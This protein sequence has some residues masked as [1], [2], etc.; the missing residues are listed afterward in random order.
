MSLNEK[1]Y[2]EV[3]IEA[4]WVFDPSN[5]S[6]NPNL[7]VKNGLSDVKEEINSELV[8]QYDE[9]IR[10]TSNKRDEMIFVWE[11]R[12]ICGTFWQKFDLKHFPVDVQPLSLEIVTR[13][14]NDE[15]ILV[16]NR[17][18][19]SVVDRDAFLGRENMMRKLLDVIDL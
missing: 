5:S 15:C 8:N 1:F 16:E 12:K 6:W 4:R 14:S 13:R 19:P 11:I 18:H 9:P 3:L 10:S 7:Y 2:A 17:V